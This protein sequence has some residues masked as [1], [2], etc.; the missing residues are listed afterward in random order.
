MQAKK[1]RTRKFK[2][3]VTKTTRYK[4]S[5][6][7]YMINLLNNDEEKI[8]LHFVDALMI[9]H[10]RKTDPKLVLIDWPKMPSRMSA[11]KFRVYEKKLC[12]QSVTILI[13]FPFFASNLGSN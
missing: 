12:L 7:P 2:P 1:R 6:I 3:R 11:Q 5:A 10:K 8:L 9:H 4:K 13:T